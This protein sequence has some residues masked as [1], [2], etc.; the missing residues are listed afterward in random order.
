[1]TVHLVVG[2]E[3]HGVV[4]H[5]QL[6]LS[7]PPFA[8]TSVVR[9]ADAQQ[10]RARLRPHPDTDVHVHFTDQLF[11]GVGRARSTLAELTAGRR[12][13]VTLHDV[14]QPSDGPLQSARSEV[15]RSVARGSRLVVVSSRHEARLLADLGLADVPVEV[16][17][18]PVLPRQRTARPGGC[19]VAIAGF[20]YPGKGHEQV[21]AAM[22][23]LPRAARL[24]NLGA[25]S[26]GHETLVDRYA[27]SAAELGRTFA[28]TGYLPDAQLL[29]AMATVRVP[30]AAPAHVSASGSLTHWNAA[31]RRPVATRNPFAEE[32][33]TLNPGAICLVD[34]L[35]AALRRAWDDPD[36]TVLPSALAVQPSPERAAH[37]LARVLQS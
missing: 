22:A 7:Q 30:V 8:G 17:A 23:G 34:D 29:D 2:P 11:G 36:S 3:H 31:G 37:Q 20:I 13:S 4:A 27:G 28:C 35:A 19:A 33:A 10:A 1:M 5:A 6:L 32:V 16:V 21:L 18:L 12:Y 25:P 24:L 9:A 15:Y 14:P 26:P